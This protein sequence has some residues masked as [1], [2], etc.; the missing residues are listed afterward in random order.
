MHVWPF[1]SLNQGIKWLHSSAGYKSKDVQVGV[2]VFGIPMKQKSTAVVDD[3]R[4]RLQ[5]WYGSWPVP[6]YRSRICTRWNLMATLSKWRI[7][8]TLAIGLP[9]TKRSAA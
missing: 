5:P 7:V 1:N 6:T 2:N 9:L 4:I 8:G 3:L